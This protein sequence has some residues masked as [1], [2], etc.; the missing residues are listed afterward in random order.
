MNKKL[1]AAGEPRMRTHS[2]ALRI[3]SNFDRLPGSR[4]SKIRAI[5]KL[6]RGQLYSQTLRRLLADKYDV[7]VGAYSYGSLLSPGA[8][9]RF[10]RIGRYV[11]V[12]P[13]VR[14]FGASHP[15]DRLSLHPLWYNP[16]LGYAKGEA[17]VE[18]SEIEIC[19]DAWIG[20]NVTIVPS[21]KRI[22]IG[23]V[24]AAGAVV[25][26]DVPD[27][28]VV[29]G[30]PAKLIKMRLSAELRDELTSLD[31]WQYDPVEADAM[32]AEI[33]HRFGAGEELHVRRT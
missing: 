11:S 13:N 8:A 29:G 14:R 15:L 18:R 25:V 16:V 30:N 5:L 10:T 22:G 7:E 9:D 19:N 12:G 6:E 2:L 31:P 1:S 4:E 32:L 26:K 3:A 23:A 33:A 27:F 20:A 24:V 17:D 21:C 28:A